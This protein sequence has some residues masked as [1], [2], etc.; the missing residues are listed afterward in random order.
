M[1]FGD[2]EGLV[3][4]GEMGSGFVGDAEGEFVRDNGTLGGAGSLYSSKNFLRT[5]GLARQ[6]M[7]LSSKRDRVGLTWDSPCP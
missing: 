3:P 7:I 6:I 4:K 2:R 1:V 5:A